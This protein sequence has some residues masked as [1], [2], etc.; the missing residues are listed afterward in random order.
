MFVRKFLNISAL[1]VF[2]TGTAL[3]QSP[4]T[5][6]IAI[7]PL[8]ID[9]GFPL[10]LVLTEKLRSKLNEPVHAKIV[11]PV[12]AF[13]RE[14]IPAGTQVLGKV[15]GLHPVG[16]WKRASS[17][18]GGDFTPLHDPEITFDTLVF[19]DGKRIP[20]QTSVSP[21]SN[22]VLRYKKG[23]TRAFTTTVQQPGN[24]LIHG[25]L[26]GL[27][28]YHP[29]FM[30]TGT[31]YKAT[32]R[33]QLNFGYVLVGNATLNGIGSPPPA[34]SIIYARLKTP[35]NSK[36]TRIGTPVDAI[37]TY[38]LYSYLDH[39]L[40]F[41]AGSRLYG[42]VADIHDAGFLARG[43]RLEIKFT[44]IEPPIT[45]MSAKFQTREIQGRLVGTDVPRD[46]NALQ[47]DE[48]GIAQL[49]RS[50]GRFLAPA[51]A[52]AGAAPMLRPGSSAFGPAFAEAYGTNVFGRVLG[53]TSGLGLP[54]SIAGLM[55][56]PVGI[57]LGAYGAGHALYSNILGR[58][59]NIA[60]PADTSIEVRVDWSTEAVP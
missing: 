60:L 19:A 51:F 34:G 38:P 2:L 17:M 52:L 58:G 53:G 1:C 57:A 41:P 4:N 9:E 25:L 54:A 10:K 18:L 13:D 48:N 30:P 32:L 7:V 21:D 56:P 22:V 3:A 47:I 6:G 36:T 35:L 46:L 14:V 49:P 12:Y 29:Q 20:I 42:E 37:L 50:K 28:P 26:W 44:K 8:T 16:K 23:Q 59:K 31:T 39:R 5:H 45:I 33:E 15:T 40:I 24:E 11:D 55:V 27:S 43:G